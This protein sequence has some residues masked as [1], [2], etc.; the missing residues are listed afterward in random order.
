MF[1]PRVETVLDLPDVRPPRA[2][3]PDLLDPGCPGC[4]W[5]A[6]EGAT[7][8]EAW[9]LRPDSYGTISPASPL[10]RTLLASEVHDAKGIAAGFEERTLFVAERRSRTV[11]RVR[12]GPVPKEPTVEK[13]AELRSRPAAL[14]SGCDGSLWVLVEREHAS[15]PGTTLVE[16]RLDAEGRAQPARPV[17]RFW[18]D[19]KG[20][21][22]DPIRGWLYVLVRE[23]DD[24]VLYEVAPE[25]LRP[26]GSLPRPV[27]GLKAW[28][29]AVL[30]DPSMLFR[31]IDT[32]L[33]GSDDPAAKEKEGE[34]R[35]IPKQLVLPTRLGAVAFDGGGSLC[36]M[37][38]DAPVV[39]RFHLG[40][41]F[42]A[43]NRAHLSAVPVRD[44]DDGSLRLRLLGWALPPG[45]GAP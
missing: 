23:L 36:L 19:P 27:L 26:G 37:G 42:V 6:A 1:D 4:L 38:E 5:L 28:T 24:S 12:A 14:A 11:L 43:R 2:L 45:A 39:L 9:R 3:L 18:G 34:E 40:R 13:L 31:P 20:L 22:V 21:A 16:I 35:K 10:E 44:A 32:G 30:R 7:G 29:D 33:V 41:P 17:A 25:C 8:L 15:D